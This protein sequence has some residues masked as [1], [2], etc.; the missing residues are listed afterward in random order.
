M[1]HAKEI[2]RIGIYS[3]EEEDGSL[4]LII[5]DD[6]PGVKPEEKER[7]FMQGYG[8]NTGLGLTLAREILE[9][10]DI[11][12]REN[13]VYGKGARFEIKVPPGSWRK[14]SAGN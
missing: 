4:L 6:G 8:K 14:K 3:R 11:K 7:I 13:G 9:V 10:T 12:I 2:A 5:N 1:R